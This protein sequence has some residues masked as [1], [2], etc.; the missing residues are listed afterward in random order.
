M[1]HPDLIE[2]SRD[3]RNVYVRAD[4]GLVVLRRDRATGELSQLPGRKGCIGHG[5]PGCTESGP[6]APGLITLSG[7]GRN[8]YATSEPNLQGGAIAIYRRAR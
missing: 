3:G 6:G 2:L 7:D 4:G 8:L 5:N 1:G